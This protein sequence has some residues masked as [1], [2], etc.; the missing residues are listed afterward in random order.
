MT[1][2]KMTRNVAGHNAGDT[3]N[4]TPKAAELLIEQG[5]AEA[6][7]APKPARKASTKSDSKPDDKTA[8]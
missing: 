5:Y 4:T 3:I 1:T 2:I 7:D 6:V 8:D